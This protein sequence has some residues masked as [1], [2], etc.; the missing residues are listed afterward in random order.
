MGS[1]HHGVDVIK[2]ANLSAV[3]VLHRRKLSIMS[4]SNHIVA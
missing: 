4:E 1:T 2:G 3:K